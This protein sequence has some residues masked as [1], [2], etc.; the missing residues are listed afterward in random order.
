MVLE[1]DSWRIEDMMNKRI[2]VIHY[3]DPFRKALEI[4]SK[5]K[6]DAIPVVND[7]GLL[8]GVLSNSRLYKA[9]LAGVD[10]DDK[11]DPYIIDAPVYINVGLNYDELSLVMRLN[12]SSVGNVPVVDDDK[13]VVGI[14][15]N[16][17]YLRTSLNIVLKSY[18]LMESIFQAMQEGI[19]TVDNNGYILRINQFAEKMFAINFAEAKGKHIN[20]V[21]PEII[22]DG[23][24][25]LGV[26]YNFKAVSAI[27]NQVPILEKDI[28]VG[29]NVVFLDVSDAEDM[30]KELQIVK[31]LHTTLNAVLSASAFGIF[32]T[33]K[34][35]E[36]KYINKIA[37]QF[38]ENHSTSVKGQLIRE[39]LPTSSRSQVAETGVS[40]VDICHLNEKNCVVAHVPIKTDDSNNNETVGVVSTIYC[41]DNKL[42]EEIARKWFSLQQQ[43]D[44]YRNQLDKQ[45]NST[46]D[47]FKHIVTKN[48]EFIQ[49]KKEAKR[50]AKSTSTVLLTGESGVGKDIFARAIHA[51]GPRSKMP[52]VKVNCVAIPETLFESELF[53]YAPG[54]FTGASKKGKM[55]FFEQANKGTIFLDEVGDMPL[56]IQV[57]ILQVLQDKQFV[58]V[59][60]INTQNVDV[61]IIAATNRN[62]REAVAKGAFREDLYYRLNVIELYLPPLRERTE[63]IIPL[64]EAFIEKYNDIL[65]TAVTG[66]STRVKQA[67]LQYSWPGNIR[68]LENAVERAANYVWEGEMDLEHLPAH[69]LHGERSNPKQSSYQVAINDVNKEIILDALRKTKGNRSA[70]ARILKISRSALYEKLSKYDI[71]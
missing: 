64:A 43:V 69:I 11:C 58:R 12:K 22:Y 15:G 4:F 24:R 31:D 51:T 53:G 59:G 62:L 61:R 26:R 71:S 21:L 7:E 16:K 57:K 36:I 41:D 55:G 70:A 2:E 29:T 33:D 8:T 14:A 20:E 42:L 28:Q 35:G 38:V 65:G 68:E 49:I 39:I 32:V 47:S 17:E 44:Y 66:M 46:K 54:S 9:L 45:R 5:Y 37:K 18:A 63:D 1:K 52:F 34:N 23:K 40:E 19:I 6:L 30:G 60:G 50:I 10:L 3:G 48:D 13:K 56:S 67:L 25:S 27:V